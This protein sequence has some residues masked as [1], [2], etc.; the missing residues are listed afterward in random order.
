MGT[1]MWVGAWLKQ[2]EW[3]MQVNAVLNAHCLR[4]E[5]PFASDRDREIFCDEQE[6]RGEEP[7]WMRMHCF[8]LAES[9]VRFT[10]ICI[11][12]AQAAAIANAAATCAANAEANGRDAIV[13]RV[14]ERRSK[15]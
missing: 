3:G 4:Q 1:E 12:E 11:P 5:M 8:S 13:T 9:R 10:Q 7:E 14:A 2:S 6:Y 15:G